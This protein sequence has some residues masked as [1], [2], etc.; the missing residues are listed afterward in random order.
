MKEHYKQ[1]SHQQWNFD[2]HNEHDDADKVLNMGH[3]QNSRA[4]PQNTSSAW[5]SD[6]V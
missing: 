1:R 2:D 6:F 3:S 4:I 5:K